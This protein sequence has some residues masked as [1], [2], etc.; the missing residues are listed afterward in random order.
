M[1]GEDSL[2]VKERSIWSEAEAPEPCIILLAVA[3]RED[4]GIMNACKDFFKAGEVAAAFRTVQWRGPFRPNYASPPDRDAELRLRIMR[5]GA[6]AQ[7]RSALN[8]RIM[9]PPLVLNSTRN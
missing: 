5:R 7:K 6:N 4:D 3:K 2:A 8:Q 9:K 1:A